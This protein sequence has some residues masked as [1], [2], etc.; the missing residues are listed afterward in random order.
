MAV[1][2][3][4]CVCV[5]VIVCVEIGLSRDSRRGPMASQ[6]SRIHQYFLALGGCLPWLGLA[7]VGGWGGE[8]FSLSSPRSTGKSCFVF[9]FVFALRALRACVRACERR[10]LLLLLLLCVCV[11]V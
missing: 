9:V 5:C 4:V 8:R 7:D 2:V 1:C 3:C 10:R 11:C 6:L